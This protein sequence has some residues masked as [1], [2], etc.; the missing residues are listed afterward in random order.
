[1]DEASRTAAKLRESFAYTPGSREWYADRLY[2]TGTPVNAAQQN[3]DSAEFIASMAPVTGEAISARDAWD[4]SGRGANALLQGNYGQAAGEYGNMLLG[5]VG[6]IPGLG[7]VARGVPKAAAWMDR[8]LPE[9]V[10]RLLDAISPSADEASRTV[11]IFAGPAAKTADQAALAKAREMKAAGASR[12]EIWKDTGWNVDDEAFP[13]FE[14]DDS[15]ARLSGVRPDAAGVFQ[16]S[17]SG[18]FS[19]V[20]HPGLASAYGPIPQMY[21]Q[22]GPGVSVEGA[23]MAGF[24][25]VPDYLR[26]A[27]PTPKEAKSVALHELQHFVQSREGRPDGGNIITSVLTPQGR[28]MVEQRMVELRRA[29]PE[30]SYDDLEY[31]AQN[32]VAMDAYRR[33]AGEVEARNVQTRM[34]MTPDERRATAPWLTQDVPDDQQ[35]VRLK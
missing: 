17:K 3:A 24:D 35:I 12:D 34:D 26:A 18:S 9:G 22:Y 20:D 32:D 8:N 27:A 30:L 7:I 6:A 29:N 14:I 19:S 16:R 21:G 28:E 13:Y 33:L 31:M 5:T 25:D 2:G 1:M 11:N 23:Y 15:A 10:N 4:A